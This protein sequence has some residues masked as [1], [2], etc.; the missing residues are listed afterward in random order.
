MDIFE[1]ETG[2]AITVALPGVSADQVDIRIDGNKIAIVGRRSL[3][4]EARA[5]IIHRLEIP[6]GRF[7]RQILLP[8]SAWQ[9][10]RGEFANGCLLLALRRVI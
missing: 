3:P 9:I 1:T 8:P 2:I 6:S 10:N 5:S 7:E 4:T